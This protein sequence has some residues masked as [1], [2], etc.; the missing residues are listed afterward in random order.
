MHFLYLFS[1]ISISEVHATV[2]DP[3]SEYL[4]SIDPSTSYTLNIV[5]LDSLILQPNLT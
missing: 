1:V 4:G 2:T 5:V 3:M